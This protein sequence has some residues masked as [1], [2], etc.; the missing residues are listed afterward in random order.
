[1]QKQYNNILMVDVPK[2][3]EGIHL[4]DGNFDV[5]GNKL[6]EKNDDLLCYGVNFWPYT[7]TLPEGDWEL[8]NPLNLV[9]EEQAYELD[10]IKL[11]TEYGI[12]EMF[13]GFQE[14]G[15][16]FY[17]TSALNS[18]DTHLSFEKTDNVYVLKQIK[19][20]QPNQNIINS[21]SKKII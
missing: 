2:D 15:R 4:S 20:I 10:D 21:I 3:A 13:K 14:V 9:T 17:A 12:I 5:A 1:M 16:Y 18:L 8:V 6:P 11:P 19:L 7:I